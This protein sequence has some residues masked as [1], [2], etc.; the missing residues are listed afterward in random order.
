MFEIVTTDLVFL[1]D[2]LGVCI[3]DKAIWVIG[4]RDKILTI[5]YSCCILIMLTALPSENTL[6][7]V[8][9]FHDSGR[10]C[11]LIDISWAT[12]NYLM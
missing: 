11:V 9:Q 7:R 5:P 8:C 3:F 6:S 12:P 10:S 2:L 4:V 1:S